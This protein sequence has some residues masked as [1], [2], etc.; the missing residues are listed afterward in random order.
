MVAVAA[1]TAR[2][3][4]PSQ[5]PARRRRP[6]SADVGSASGTVFFAPASSCSSGIVVFGLSAQFRRVARKMFDFAFALS[7]VFL[8]RSL[9]QQTQQRLLIVEKLHA[10][11]IAR[12]RQTN[13]HF[14]FD[15]ARMRRH[16]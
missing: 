8:T 13:R 10:E 2:P 9:T 16:H 4:K 1:G 5:A 12:A 15:R 14:G 11:R 6:R 3:A 7:F